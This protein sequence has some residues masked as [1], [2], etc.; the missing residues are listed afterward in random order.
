MGYSSKRKAG[1]VMMI[2]MMSCGERSFVVF[3]FFF[4]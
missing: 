1:N 4:G 3:V 2:I